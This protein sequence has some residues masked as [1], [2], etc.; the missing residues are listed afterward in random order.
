VADGLLRAPDA[1]A[2]S[3]REAERYFEKS[4]SRLTPA[5]D[6]INRTLV[7]ALDCGHL[8][9]LTPDKPP[10][11]AGISSKDWK[12]AFTRYLQRKRR[13]CKLLTSGQQPGLTRSAYVIAF[14]TFGLLLAPWV[15]NRGRPSGYSGHF[16]RKID[17]GIAI[18]FFLFA[19]LILL[20]L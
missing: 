13:L 15:E 9:T 20:F 16:L 5:N 1:P 18:A 2:T 17:A 10:S 11:G 19:V 7:R 3:W 6:R 12:S 4:G 14:F 8:S